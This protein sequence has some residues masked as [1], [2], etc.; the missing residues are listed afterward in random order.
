MWN[1]YKSDI[2]LIHEVINYA[3]TTA[4]FVWFHGVLFKDPDKISSAMWRRFSDKQSNT[5]ECRKVLF[6]LKRHNNASV[7]KRL[8]KQISPSVSPTDLQWDTCSA[9]W[10]LVLCAKMST[11]VL[12]K[13]WHWLME[14][15]CVKLKSTS[16]SKQTGN[17]QSKERTVVLII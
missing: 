13:Y 3:I 17:M 2:P 1:S 5:W 9:V 6:L 15:E 10:I 14:A 7:V 4:A 11:A 16:T 12:H 8:Q